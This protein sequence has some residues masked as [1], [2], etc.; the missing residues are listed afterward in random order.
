MPSATGSVP[1][2]TGPALVGA[3]FAAL[4]LLPL[5]ALAL[6]GTTGPSRIVAHHT[7]GTEQPRTPDVTSAS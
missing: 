6:R 4:T 3:V 7:T 1:G 5:I 2:L